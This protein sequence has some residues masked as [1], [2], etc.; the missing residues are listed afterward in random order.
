MKRSG[1]DFLHCTEPEPSA[2]TTRLVLGAISAEAN[3][4]ATHLVRHL[5]GDAR[6]RPLAE[7]PPQ[8]SP[9]PARKTSLLGFTHMLATAAEQSG[10]SQLGLEMAGAEQAPEHSIFGGLFLYAPTVGEALHALTRYFPVSQTGTTVELT[11]SQGVAR[12]SYEIHDPTVG[13]RLQDAAYT[14]GK[15]CRSLRRS[16]GQAWTLDQVTLAVQAPRL[17]EPYRRFFQA[18]VTF[19]AQSTALCFSS[20]LLELPIA[21]ADAQHYAR[22]CSHLERLMPGRSEPGLLE[23]ALR[24]W[25]VHATRWGSATLEHAAADFGVTPRTMQR[26]LKEQDIRFQE[27]LAQVRMDTARRMLAESRMPVAHIAEQLGFSETSAFTRAF[28]SHA[29]LSP[30]AFRQAALAHA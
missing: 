8:P 10:R 19:G 9:P 21:S 13:D 27:L 18:P 20:R 2:M 24:A 12:L 29:R 16:A 5:L 26:R 7:W 22:F 4:L 28:R 30:R 6:G 17:H 25:M 15:V 11:Q 1:R 23:D 14:L 3:R